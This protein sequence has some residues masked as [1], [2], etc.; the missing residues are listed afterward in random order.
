MSAKDFNNI[1]SD[2]PKIISTPPPPPT[3][4]TNN[5]K[6]NNQQASEDSNSD[7]EDPNSDYQQFKRQL[8]AEEE[9]KARRLKGKAVENDDTVYKISTSTV[10]N[11]NS[12]K[13]ILK[14]EKS[15]DRLPTRQ[16]NF[17]EGIL[18]AEIKKETLSLNTKKE[19]VKQKEVV[20]EPKKMSLFKQRMMARQQEF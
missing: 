15:T 2:S 18:Q 16:V 3:T 5:N 20:K 4:T 7:S 11:K 13:G 17:E 19:E 14:K 9:E 12:P 10:E 1:S 6:S 8:K